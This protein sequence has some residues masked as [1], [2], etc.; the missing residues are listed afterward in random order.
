MTRKTTK[1]DKEA[2]ESPFLENPVYTNFHPFIDLIKHLEPEERPKFYYNKKG[3]LVCQ[4][5]TYEKNT[6]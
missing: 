4:L 6:K 2:E 1:K 3:W 5:V